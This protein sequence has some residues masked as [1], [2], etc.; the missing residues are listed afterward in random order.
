MRNPEELYSW[1][2]DVEF[3]TPP[4]LV[5]AFSGF[6]DAGNGVR[7]AADHILESC[8]QHLIATFD[9]DEVLDYRARRPRMSYVVD[10]FAS[11]DIPQISLHEVT[12]PTGARFLLLVGPEPD[13]QWQR[14]IAAV[15][16]IVDRFAVR[17]AVGLSAIPWPAPHTRPLGLTIHGSE[18][19]LGEIEVPGHVGAMLELSLGE[20][21]VPSMGV[22]A[23]VP[24][25]LVQF[26]YPRGAQA[27]L[28]GI[29]A[30]TGLSVSGAGLQEAAD[31]ADREVANQLE[32]NDEFGVIVTSLEA[33]YDQLAAGQAMA[34]G[35]SELAPDGEM[36]TGD[37]IAAQVEEFLNGLRDDEERKDA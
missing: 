8:D 34:A 26:E 1:H 14:F 33:Q 35:L 30:V 17:L 5:H 18:P 2:R 24:H 37:E 9:V 13:Y 23:Q 6:V 12:D 20:Q 36:P 11:V 7:I 21:G 28:E 27:L 25:Y 22:T 4:V 16:G 3:D 15:Q 32:G 19:S 31:A 29:A 10:H